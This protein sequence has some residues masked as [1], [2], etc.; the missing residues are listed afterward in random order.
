[1]L[2]I[3]SNNICSYLGAAPLVQDSAILSAAASIVTVEARHQ[4]FLRS[5]LFHHDSLM[6]PKILTWYFKLLVV[7][8]L[9][10]KPLM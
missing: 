3:L 9:Y 8:L 10:H 1:M 6:I 5:M 7:I 2:W 4:T